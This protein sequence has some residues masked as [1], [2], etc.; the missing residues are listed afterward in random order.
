MKKTIGN[1]IFIIYAIIAVFVTICLLSFNEFKVSEF[2]DTSLVIVDNQDLE[3]NFNEGDLVLV[4]KGK[5]IREGDTI[6]FYNTSADVVEVTLAQVQKIEKVSN[7]EYTYTVEGDVAISSEYVLGNAEDVTKISNVGTVLGVLESKWGFLI[8]IVFPSLLAFIYEITVVFTEIR[9]GKKDDDEE[10]EDEETDD[11]KNKKDKVKEPVKN[12]NKKIEQTKENDKKE[13]IEETEEPEEVIE[14]EEVVEE[15]V[16][17]E[18]K[19]TTKKTT[20]KATT[21]KKQEPKLEDDSNEEK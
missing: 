11:S 1:I 13:E 5:R 4:D 6:F 12:N 20:K 17:E 21:K 3:P 2:G 15:E 9:E 14:A 7:L 8:L 19:K 16:K 18:P 10:S